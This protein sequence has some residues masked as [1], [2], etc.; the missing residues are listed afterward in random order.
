MQGVWGDEQPDSNSLKVHIF[1]LRKQVD[2]EQDNKLLHTIT[3][4]GFAIKELR[5]E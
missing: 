5:Q 1:N 3:G 4:K 2:A